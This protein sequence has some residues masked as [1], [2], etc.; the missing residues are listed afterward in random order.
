MSCRSLSAFKSSV[1]RATNCAADKLRNWP[2]VSAC[3]WVLLKWS[4]WAVVRPAN[5]EVLMPLMRVWS[6]PV[7]RLAS[8]ARN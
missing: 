7:T 6:K 1:P 3:H 8:M 2:L 5:W 4:S